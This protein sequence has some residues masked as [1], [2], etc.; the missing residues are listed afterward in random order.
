MI[1]DTDYWV[2]D[3][4]GDSGADLEG[5]CG[6]CASLKFAKHICYTTLFKMA[7]QREFGF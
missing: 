6:A 7:A 2:D 1:G 3:T 4:L 5:A